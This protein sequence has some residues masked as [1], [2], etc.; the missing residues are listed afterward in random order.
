MKHIP[1]TWEEL[2]E[3]LGED[4]GYSYLVLDLQRWITEAEARATAAERDR[5]LGL[6]MVTYDDIAEL[7]PFDRVGNTQNASVALN[8]IIRARIAPPPPVDPRIAVGVAA[9]H[10]K[11]MTDG[12]EG[13]D[14]AGRL[15]IAL[16]AIDAMGVN[17]G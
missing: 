6:A 9:L 11:R 10:A 7:F 17:N 14:T 5:C 12:I 8:K 4:N 16:A 1:T 2:C 3:W 13:I 15:A